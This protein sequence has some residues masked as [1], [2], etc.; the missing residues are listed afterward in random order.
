M[1]YCCLKAKPSNGRLQKANPLRKN[2]SN[3]KSTKRNFQHEQQWRKENDKLKKRAQQDFLTTIDTQHTISIQLQ[4]ER[5]RTMKC[6]LSSS[7]FLSPFAILKIWQHWKKSLQ[8][9]NNIPQRR[10][11]S[12][13]FFCSFGL[14]F[15]ITPSRIPFTQSPSKIYG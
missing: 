10:T 3:F 4:T 15:E 12:P 1:F 5:Y 2:D 9:R 6:Y 8:T 7:P 14:S 11:F 13:V